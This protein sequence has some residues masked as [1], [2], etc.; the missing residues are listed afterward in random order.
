MATETLALRNLCVVYCD[1]ANSTALLSDARRAGNESA[2]VERLT[3]HL[4]L[5]AECFKKWGA[6]CCKFRGDGWLVTFTYDGE[7]DS[8]SVLVLNAKDM[9]RVAR[10]PLPRR[11][12][13]GF[14]ATWVPGA[15]IGQGIA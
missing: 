13:I 8:S 10:I 11:V 14:H 4:D 9:S 7:D 5:W 12:P 2:Y 6:T 1:I 3:R 15:L